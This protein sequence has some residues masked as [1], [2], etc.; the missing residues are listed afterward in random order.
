MTVYVNAKFDTVDLGIIKV[1]RNPKVDQEVLAPDL[2]AWFIT[3]NL[4]VKQWQASRSAHQ[5]TIS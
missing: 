2:N 5:W 4:I 3:N 1:L